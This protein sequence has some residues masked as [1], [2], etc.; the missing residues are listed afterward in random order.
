[1]NGDISLSDFLTQP[2]DE[3]TNDPFRCNPQNK[4]ATLNQ[5][6]EG[7]IGASLFDVPLSNSNETIQ[8]R[9]QH[10]L[11]IN[12]WLTIGDSYFNVSNIRNVKIKSLLGFNETQNGFYYQISIDGS[13]YNISGPEAIGGF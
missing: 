5:P 11:K 13:T 2:T 3:Q 4:S 8:K 7:A 10:I 12:A 1:M 6:N 9:V